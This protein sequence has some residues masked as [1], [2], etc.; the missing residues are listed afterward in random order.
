MF[1]E[2]IIFATAAD[3]DVEFT[4]DDIFHEHELCAPFSTSLLPHHDQDIIQDVLCSTLQDVGFAS[5]SS[6]LIAGKNSVLLHDCFNHAPK[7]T[8]NKRN[9]EHLNLLQSHGSGVVTSSIH[10]LWRAEGDCSCQTQG[11]CSSLTG[12]L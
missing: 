5:P 11:F 3:N 9:L 12:P 8:H 6:Q 1:K 10:H 2:D 7:L 4:S